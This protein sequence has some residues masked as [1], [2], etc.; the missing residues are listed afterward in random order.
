[1]EQQDEEPT[2]DGARTPK[3]TTSRPRATYIAMGSTETSPRSDIF[4]TWTEGSAAADSASEAESKMIGSGVVCGTR[5][6]SA[7]GARRRVASRVVLG[8]TADATVD[9]DFSDP[10]PVGGVHTAQFAICACVRVVLLL[11]SRR[12]KR[13]Q[14]RQVPDNHP[15]R[16]G[17]SSSKKA[18]ADACR[19]SAP[20]HQ[21]CHRTVGKVSRACRLGIVPDRVPP[22]MTSECHGSDREEWPMTADSTVKEIR[23]AR[24]QPHGLSRPPQPRCS[25]GRCAWSSVRWVPAPAHALGARCRSGRDGSGGSADSHLGSL[26]GAHCR[27]SIRHGVNA[28][29][30]RV[31]PE[32][33]GFVSAAPVVVSTPQVTA[34]ATP[35]SV[36]AAPVAVST[37]QVTATATPLRVS[38]AGRGVDPAGDGYGYPGFGVGSAGRGV[39]PA[40]DGYGYPGFG[41]GSAGRGVD[42]EV[43]ATATPASV[44]APPVAVSTPQ[45]TAT[46]TPA[47]VSAP[48]VSGVD[49]VGD[50][51]GYPGFG[52]GSA[53][54]GVDPAGHCFGS[55]RHPHV[56]GRRRHRAAVD[57]TIPPVSISVPSTGFASPT[58]PTLDL[59][60]LPLR[61]AGSFGARTVIVAGDWLRSSGAARHRCPPLLTR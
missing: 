48:P 57:V 49:P 8:L 51:Y 61:V 3:L 28:G 5:R 53:G 4:E 22:W 45:V 20:R 38:C 52:V 60:S 46:A 2:C 11:E 33:D 17:S 59:S 13:G 32:G 7:S 1:M 44:S 47:S 25:S 36:S 21:R 18:S 34:T 40:G 10:D 37:P 30:H 23:V 58:A 27:R 50:G 43:T 54:R 16:P 55:A 35:A 24:G 39:D 26:V 31:H 14:H 9:N 12:R 6:K 15:P 41:V 56:A 19:G 29:D 42:P